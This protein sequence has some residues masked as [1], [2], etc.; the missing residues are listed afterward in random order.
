MVEDAWGAMMFSDIPMKRE[1]T[2]ETKVKMSEAKR[3]ERHVRAVQPPVYEIQRRSAAGES[4][5]LIARGLGL[6]RTVVGD[7]LRGSHWSV[8]AE[9]VRR[10]W[11]KPIQR[12]EAA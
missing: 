10:N 11:N 2:A 12:I 6:K 9:Y 5:S 3:G 4:C 1:F 7:V 8:R